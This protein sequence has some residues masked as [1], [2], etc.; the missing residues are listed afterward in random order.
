MRRSHKKI[1]GACFV[2]DQLYSDI[3]KIKKA[4]GLKGWILQRAE[5]G[6]PYL[7]KFHEE[8][9]RNRDAFRPYFL[10][11]EDKKIL[12]TRTIFIENHRYH[13]R[14]SIERSHPY[15]KESLKILKN[16][17]RKLANYSIESIPYIKVNAVV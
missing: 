3:K 4:L 10:V 14:V 11:T 9:E 15:I 17:E 2:V 5:N 1:L 16:Y 12:V 13:D 7:T 8:E 6:K